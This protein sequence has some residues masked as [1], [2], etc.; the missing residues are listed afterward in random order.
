M[1]YSSMWLAYVLLFVWYVIIIVQSFMAYGTAY[2]YT[3]K[4]G[5]NG[6]SLFGWFFIFG[7]AAIIPGLG[8]YLWAASKDSSKTQPKVERTVQDNNVK[9]CPFCFKEINGWE[10]FCPHCGKIINDYENDREIMK[11]P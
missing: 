9:N 1:G 5:D 4:G 2:R 11:N 7:L 8:Y 3:K 6:V 10:K